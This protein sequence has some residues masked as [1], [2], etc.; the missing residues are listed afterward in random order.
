MHSAAKDSPR[1]NVHRWPGLTAGRATFNSRLVRAEGRFKVLSSWIVD[2]HLELFL[3]VELFLA[4]LQ[5]TR[6]T[7]W[8]RR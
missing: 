4:L 6:V 5:V 1:T 2:M 3:A 7:L 8:I